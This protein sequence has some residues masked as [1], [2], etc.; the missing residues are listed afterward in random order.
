M[1]DRSV[2]LKTFVF[3][4]IFEP[5]SLEGQKNQKSERLPQRFGVQSLQVISY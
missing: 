5:K 2:S 4:G 1:G 3:F